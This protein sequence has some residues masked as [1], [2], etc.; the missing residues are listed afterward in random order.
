MT[1]ARRLSG[2]VAI[3]LLLSAC[4]GFSLPGFGG[5]RHDPEAATPFDRWQQK[6]VHNAFDQGESVPEQLEQHRFR[7]VEFD[8]HN[9]KRGR[10]SL[11]GDWYVYHADFPGFD[12]SSCTTLGTCLEQV[13]AWH[14]AHADHDV[15]TLFID[16]K[17]D[18]APGH[19]PDLL[20]RKLT[21]GLDDGAALLR[22]RSVLSRCPGATTLREAVTGGCG[23]PTLGELRGKIIVALTGGDMCT[24]SS[25]LNAY[26]GS[27]EVAAGRAAFVAPNVSRACPFAGHDQRAPQA[28]LFNLD[29]TN[30]TQAASIA[31]AGLVSRAYYGGLTGGLD[32]A[33]AWDDAR[34]A[35]AQFL[36]TDRI[37]QR[38]YPWVDR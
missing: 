29:H 17:D 8:V 12:G 3:P 11:H 14:Q 23:W 20:D 6:S 19:D 36:A 1:C 5:V 2:M 33:R 22:P 18:F 28:I 13:N 38:R 16:L 25:K 34:T 31:R 9:G 10:R 32:D 35:G 37:D 27:S 30:V 15:L 7:S 4:A 21:Q 26:A 24:R